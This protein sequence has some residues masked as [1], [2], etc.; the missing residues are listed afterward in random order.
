VTSTLEL[1]PG[2]DAAT[3]R[4]WVRYHSEISLHLTSQ[5]TALESALI[6]ITAYIVVGCIEAYRRYPELM[7]EIAE[8]MPPEEIGRAGRQVGTQIDTV[9]LWSI[10]NFHL[11]GRNVL[12]A[13]GMLDH[14]PSRRRGR[15]GHTVLEL[16]ARHR[17]CV[18]AA[19]RR[20]PE[21]DDSTQRTAHFL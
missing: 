21:P 4:R 6:P 1:P 17:C 5:R 20:C 2:W 13:A 18:R 12:A 15:C 7:L 16:G 11:V 10:A 9:R 19:R 3:V 14:T 8:A